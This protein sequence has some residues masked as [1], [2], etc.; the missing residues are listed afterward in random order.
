M[1]LKLQLLFDFYRNLCFQI[2]TFD[3]AVVSYEIA[4]MCLEAS[5]ELSLDSPLTK[6]PVDVNHQKNDVLSAAALPPA[7]P[8]VDNHDDDSGSEPP[9]LSVSESV[10]S[11]PMPKSQSVPEVTPT[12]KARSGAKVDQTFCCW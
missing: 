8:V 4:C 7:E 12:A 9:K 1:Q 3:A 5:E 2:R 11:P 6:E 10:V